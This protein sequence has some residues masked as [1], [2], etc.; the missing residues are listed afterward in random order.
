MSARSVG[1]GSLTVVAAQRTDYQTCGS[2]DDGLQTVQI[3]ASQ[4]GECGVAVVQFRHDEN[5]TKL[6]ITV[7]NVA[8]IVERCK[9][10]SRSL[11]QQ[12]LS[13]V[14][15]VDHTNDGRRVVAVI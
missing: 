13:T 11:C 12:N 14:E 15:P 4:A 2:V 3:V 5:E 6:E 8:S 1:C 7:L 10:A 9:S